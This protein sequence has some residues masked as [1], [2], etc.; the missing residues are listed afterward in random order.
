MKT[1]NI[2]Q[3]NTP[4]YWDEHQ[5]A[6]DFGLRQEKY[7]ELAGSG[8]RIVELGCGLSPFLGEINKDKSLFL[9]AFGLDFSPKTVEEARKLFP[10]VVYDVGD[11]IDTPYSNKL[12]DVS[13]AGEVIEHLTEPLKLIKEM[14]RITKK[15]I[16][17]ST[18]HLEFEDPEHV[19]EFDEKDLKELLSPYGEV[20]TETIHSERFPGRSYI[21]AV[22]ELR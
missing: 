13:V 12:F 21:F 3:I 22:C 17:I 20:T 6:F 2:P 10:L 5:T 9:Q 19:C 16:I 1:F 15:R 7:R 8:D 11:V 18:P 4:E 14:V